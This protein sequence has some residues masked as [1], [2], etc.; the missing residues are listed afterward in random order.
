[1][2]FEHALSPATVK[3]FRAGVEQLNTLRLE[4]LRALGLAKEAEMQSAAVQASISN[5][6]AII[7]QT[8]GLPAPVRPYQLSAD[9]TKLIG[10]VP[11]TPIAAPR[12]APVVEL[13]PAI[14]EPA[15]QVN[16]V[17]HSA[18]EV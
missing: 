10:E 15:G 8:E 17:D 4:Q 14:A 16:G 5:Q 2:K 9:C 1:M 11:D 13:A 18:M 12:P 7:E 3:V 6:V